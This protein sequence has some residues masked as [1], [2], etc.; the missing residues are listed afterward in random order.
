MAYIILGSCNNVV[1][2]TLQQEQHVMLLLLHS[3]ASL[4]YSYS[5]LPSS[6]EARQGQQLVWRMAAA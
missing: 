4:I 3:V 1:S 6:M 5:G 2:Q